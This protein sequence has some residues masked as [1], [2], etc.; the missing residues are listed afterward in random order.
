VTRRN[1][2]LLGGL[3]LVLG[4]A[5]CAIVDKERVLASGRTVLVELA[6]VDPRSL[7]Q[8]D[9][10]RL[11]YAIARSADVRRGVGWPRSG[12]IVVRTD[13]RGIAQFVRRH[14]GEAL[15][16]GEQLLQYRVRGNRFRIGSDAFFFEEGAAG[17]YTDARYGELR[18]DDNGES[19]LV[20]LRDGELR[21]LE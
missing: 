8:G 9:Y 2:L 17:R 14:E 12:R 10:M 11:D 4:V 19:V 21:R 15:A 13:D 5:T 1:V 18:V 16:S 7:I 3:A 6:P 20:G